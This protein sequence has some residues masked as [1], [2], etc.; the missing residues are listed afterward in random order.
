MSWK[1]WDIGEVVEA[2]D[3]QALVQDQVV[4]TY[5]DSTARGSA[6]GTAVSEGMVSYLQDSNSVQV[7]DGSAWQAVAPVSHNYIINGAFDI[8]QRGTAVSQTTVSNTYTIDRW[9]TTLNQVTSGTLTTRQNTADKQA[10]DNYCAEIDATAVVTTS[11]INLTQLLETMQVV[12][13]RG[14]TITLSFSAKVSTGTQTLTGYLRDGTDTNGFPITSGT[15][16]NFSFDA[17]TSWQRFTFT[18]NVQAG[19]NS[20]AIRF[21]TPDGFS[22]KLFI[23]Q[24]QLEAGSVATPFRRNAP[25]LQG[26][27]AACQRYYYNR[28]ADATLGVLATGVGSG[29]GFVDLFIELPV[30]MRR[31]PDATLGWTGNTAD[32]TV[33][34]GNTGVAIAGNPGVNGNFTSRNVAAV[35]FPVTSGTNASATFV[36]GANS[37]A[38]FAFSAEL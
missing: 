12:P 34:Q 30:T 26:E 36:H 16:T 25:S 8:W 17:N 35:F 32:Y 28:I 29:T 21:T 13:L 27:L 38:Y 23:S 9:Y 7:Y 1:Q 11:V 18:H 20:L 5:A 37:A 31:I 33:V 14:Q 6:L 19:A 10:T 4:Q 2:G 22:D 24:V 3:F 15:Q